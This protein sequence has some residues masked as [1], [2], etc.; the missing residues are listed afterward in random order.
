[1]AKQ[2]KPRFDSILGTIKG[3]L[4]EDSL[5]TGKAWQPETGLVI[6][7]KEMEKAGLATRHFGK[8]ID[9]GFIGRGKK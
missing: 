1:M 5:Y 3:T 8:T 7:R 4:V 2:E 6:E 9:L